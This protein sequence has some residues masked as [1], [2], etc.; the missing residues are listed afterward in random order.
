MVDNG[1]DIS[2]VEIIENVPVV[3]NGEDASRMESGE[4]VSV[5]HRRTYLW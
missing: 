2:V 5:L 3:V 1:E 4:K